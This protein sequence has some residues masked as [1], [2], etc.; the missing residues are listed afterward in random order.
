MNPD[1]C[2]G[3]DSLRQVPQI[4]QY[5][6]NGDKLD[7]PIIEEKPYCFYYRLHLEYVQRTYRENK[8]C[9]HYHN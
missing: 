3:C 4:K 1:N 9:M 7:E 5:D 8:D 2:K 6:D